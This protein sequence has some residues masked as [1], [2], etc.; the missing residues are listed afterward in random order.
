VPDRGRFG[1]EVEEVTDVFK[2]AVVV[3]AAV[4]ETL[5]DVVDAAAVVVAAGCLIFVNFNPAG[6]LF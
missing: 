2:L 1:E 5:E 3:V 6:R 4:V